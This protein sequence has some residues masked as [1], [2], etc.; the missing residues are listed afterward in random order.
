MALQENAD[1]RARRRRHGGLAVVVPGGVTGVCT[2][3]SP[4]VLVAAQQAR[5]S[6]AFAS[7]SPG[8]RVEKYPRLNFQWKLTRNEIDQKLCGNTPP[9]PLPPFTRLP[10]GGADV[11]PSAAAPLDLPVAGV[12]K[13]ALTAQDLSH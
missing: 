13:L 7:D 1:A 6:A 8:S 5:F 12:A 9:P 4:R 3:K 11:D 10:V 2:A